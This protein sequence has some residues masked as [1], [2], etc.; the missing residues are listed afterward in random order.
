MLPRGNR[1]AK[2]SIN[3]QCRA[4]AHSAAAIRDDADDAARSLALRVR[5]RDHLPTTRFRRRV[6]EQ[7][8]DRVCC[9][10]DRTRVD[11]VSLVVVVVD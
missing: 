4:A 9:V 2:Q 6:R 8:N 7:T 3:V 11:V 1:N 5:A 10:R